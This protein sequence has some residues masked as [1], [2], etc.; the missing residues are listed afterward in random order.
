MNA[1]PDRPIDGGCLCGRIRYRLARIPTDV[2]HCHCRICQRSTGAPLVTWATVPRGELALLAGEPAWHR[3]SPAARRGFCPACGSQVFFAF[4][5]DFAATRPDAP[6]D[7]AATIDVAVAGLDEPD[8][9]RPT[10]NIWVGSRRAFLHG[11]DAGLPDWDDEGPAPA[12][13]RS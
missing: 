2:A 8:L 10:R 1:A 5:A 9:C 12:E 13:P 3:S 6:D 4:D 11:F 7:S